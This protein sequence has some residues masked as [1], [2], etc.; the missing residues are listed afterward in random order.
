ML[1]EVF[2]EQRPG[3]WGFLARGAGGSAEDL[4]QETFLRV[5]DHRESLRGDT[6]QAEREGA[7][8]YLWRV[9]RNLMIDEI[10]MRQRRGEIGTGM[11]PD[12]IASPSH[13]AEVVFA[14][15][16]RAMRET[17]GTLPNRRARRCLQLWLDGL[18]VVSISRH[19]SLSIDQVRG[20]LQ[21]GRSEVIRRASKRLRIRPVQPAPEGGE[22]R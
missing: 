14:D 11:E 2:R 1:A 3:L 18:D 8:R 5:W 9:A 21:R 10:R 19:L 12:G 17:V 6:E 20:L 22:A 4:L 16:V 15:A 13:E 7:R